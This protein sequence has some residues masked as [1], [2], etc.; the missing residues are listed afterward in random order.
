MY[1]VRA[2]NS[3]DLYQ[4]LR[5]AVSDLDPNYLQRLSADDTCRA[6][7]LILFYAGVLPTKFMS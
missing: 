2:P 3:L 4:A 5:F 7:K 6:N 1:L